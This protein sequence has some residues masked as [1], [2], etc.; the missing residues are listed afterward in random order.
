MIFHPGGKAIETTVEVK[1]ADTAYFRLY[2]MK[3]VA[4]RFLLPSDTIREYLVN[5]T[6]TRFLGY[7]HPSDIVGTMLKRGDQSYPIVGVLAD[8]HSKSVRQTIQPLAYSTRTGTNST[9]H[10]ALPAHGRTSGGWTATIGAIEKEFNKIYPE[11]PFSYSF[12]DENIAA[13]Y[14]K[15]QDTARLLAWS[16][17]LT[18]FI[19][20]LGLL[21]L[22][23][24]TTSQRTKEI[25][26]RKVLGASVTQIVT[27]LSKDFVRLVLLAFLISAP[28]AWWGVHWWLQDYAYRTSINWWIFLVCGV[29]ML[30]VALLT[31]SV[32]TIRSAV[33]NPTEALRSE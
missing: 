10:I 3:L 31:L 25:G 7:K 4:G 22:V 14:K 16:T 28:F 32:Q 15:E 24:Y 12:L 27:L 9:F 19:S 6:L 2:Q 13:F 5:E 23:M 8:F 21:G 29:A 30:F 20:C 26:V 18:I 33:A 17:G 1:D 11:E